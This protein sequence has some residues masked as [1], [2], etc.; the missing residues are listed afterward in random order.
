MSRSSTPALSQRKHN[1]CFWL[2][3]Q[4][5]GDGPE[6]EGETYAAWLIPL[7]TNKSLTRMHHPNLLYWLSMHPRWG[8]GQ[9]WNRKAPNHLYFQ[10]ARRN[11]GRI[12]KHLK[13]RRPYSGWCV[14]LEGAC[15]ARSPQL[16]LII[17][18][19][20][21]FSGRAT[22]AGNFS[23]PVGLLSRGKMLRIKKSSC[24]RAIQ[25][26]MKWL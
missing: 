3:H 23:V 15:S 20:G 16:Q 21:S 5:S 10:S 1:C 11:Q 22:F 12:S 8:V 2:N 18:D 6:C 14:T 7:S 19:F 4:T 17:K 26:I 9:P 24:Y 13:K 25:V